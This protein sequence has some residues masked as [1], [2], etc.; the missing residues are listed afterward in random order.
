MADVLKNIEREAEELFEL[1][2]N[3]NSAGAITMLSLYRCSQL[4][5]PGENVIGQIDAFA[6]DYLAEFLRSDSFSQAKAV[7]E[8]LPEE[9]LR[10]VAFSDFFKSN[11]RFTS[12]DNK[13]KSDL[14]FVAC[15]IQVK[16]ALSARWNRNMPR[17]MTRNQIELFNPDDLWLGKTLYQ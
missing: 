11:F 1:S 13:I 3:E 5:F 10:T 9:V 17:L 7:K 2:G 12:E 6:R 8:N 14:Q 4:N 15:F 16:Y